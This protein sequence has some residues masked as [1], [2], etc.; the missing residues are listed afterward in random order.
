MPS[1]VD[2]CNLALSHLGDSATVTSIDP[3]EGSAQ[4]E[5]CARFYPLARDTL[6]EQHQWGF[7]TRRAAL[8]LLSSTAGPEWDY[9]Y[10]VPNGMLNIIAVLPSDATDDFT[11]APLLA[12]SQ[13]P[14]SSGA[15]YVP[16][17][18]MLETLA[19]GTQVVLTDQVNAWAR[20]TVSIT[21]PT[22]FSPLFVDCLSWLLASHLA[23]PILKGDA[24][25]AAARTCFAT[26]KQ[27]LSDADESDSNQRQTKPMHV[28]SWMAGR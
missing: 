25:V 1:V 6:L 27:R 3:P 9:T 14:V 12:W 15:R 13:S 23:G 16:Q 11:E 21:D 28:V 22:K 24:G 7:T 17:P 5:H 4:A 2:I 26:Y 18:F 10:A 20:Y 19:D 8:A